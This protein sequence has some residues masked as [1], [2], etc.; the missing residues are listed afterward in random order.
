MKL[1]NE[2]CQVGPKLPYNYLYHLCEETVYLPQRI[3]AMRVIFTT[4]TSYSCIVYKVTF[5]CNGYALCS[6]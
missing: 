1:K 2:L 3:Y 4:N 6:L 5:L